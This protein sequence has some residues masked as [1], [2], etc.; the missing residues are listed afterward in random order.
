MKS[1]VEKKAT[2]MKKTQ[3]AIQIQAMIAK[4]T[5][6]ALTTTTKKV[7]LQILKKH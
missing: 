3:I 2:E 1:R 5:K 6:V 7:R 4:E